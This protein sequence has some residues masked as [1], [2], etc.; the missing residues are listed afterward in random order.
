MTRDEIYDHLAKVYLGKR[1]G[2]SQKK[3]RPKKANRP[4]LVINI[5]ITLV[6]VLSM[7]YG[8]TAFLA[9]RDD[10]KSQIFYALNNEPIHID[11]NLNDP[12]PE[13]KTF[14][15][16]IPNKDVSKYSALNVSLRGMD[17]AYPGIVKVVVANQ[18]NERATYYIQNVDSKWQKT[19][20]PFD[21]LNLTDWTT[22]TSVS[23]VL[24]AWNVDF[25]RGT[26]L[27]DGVSFSN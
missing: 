27:I 3:G 4:L 16:D 13:T 6:I 21:K 18:K 24:E 15:I 10:L 8:F 5:V 2:V 12:Y 11:Y 25:R 7:V 14:S 17:G 9:R 20:I 26:L 23:F 1:E 19:S 22:I